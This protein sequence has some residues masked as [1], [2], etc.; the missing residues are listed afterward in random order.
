LALADDRI[1]VEATIG[2]LTGIDD[3]PVA[4]ANLQP[5]ITHETQVTFSEPIS[6]SENSSYER[7]YAFPPD[8][9]LAPQ[10][11]YRISGWLRGSGKD[12]GIF[13]LDFRTD[14]QGR[15]LPY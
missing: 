4:Q 10:T 5:R 12:K 13:E 6:L 15:P 8:L 1:P 3:P 2:R 14:A 7:I 11:A 9:K